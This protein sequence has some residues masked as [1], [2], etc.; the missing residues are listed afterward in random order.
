VNR[1]RGTRK[2]GR[3]SERN[4]LIAL[5]KLSGQMIPRLA[6]ADGNGRR[7]LVV[8]LSHLRGE[9]AFVADFRDQ[10]DLRFEPIDV[11]FFILQ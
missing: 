10:V 1:S 8:G 2:R 6:A 3:I 5:P 4:S 7:L 9:V 11:G